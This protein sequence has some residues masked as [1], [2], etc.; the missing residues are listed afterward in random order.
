VGQPVSNLK[1]VAQMALA[2][3]SPTVCCS[4]YC[5]SKQ[6]RQRLTRTLWSPTVPQLR[7]NMQQPLC[8]DIIRDTGSQ[9]ILHFHYARVVRPELQPCTLCMCTN[10]LYVI[11][12]VDQQQQHQRL[13]RNATQHVACREDAPRAARRSGLVSIQARSA[14]LNSRA[15]AAWWQ[16][17]ARCVSHDDHASRDSVR[18]RCP[19]SEG[20]AGCSRAWRSSK[21]GGRRVPPD[22]GASR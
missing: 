1:T 22:R 3:Y 10:T 18:L 5:C 16:L 15:P 2:L 6:R 11:A 21:R 4:V 20:A 13:P 19:L 9:S 14:L 12:D 17:L 7:A 8:A